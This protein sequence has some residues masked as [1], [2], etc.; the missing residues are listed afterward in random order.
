VLTLSRPEL[1]E[2]R[3]TWGAGHR[4]FSS[5]YLEPLPRDAMQRL[6]DGLVPGL[7]GAARDQI[8]ERAEGVPLYAVETA[9]MLLDRGLLVEDGP[10]YRLTGTVD[11]LEVPE[12]LHALIA[13]RLD[14]LTAAE[15]RLLQD[16]SVL[17]KTFT[18]SALAALAGLEEEEIDATL[19]SLVRKEVLNVQADPRS[20]EHGQYGFLQDLLRHVAYETLSKRDRLTRH[21]KAGAHLQSAFPDDEEVVEVLASHYLD[22]F[23]LAA[24]TD[25][26][27]E[28]GVRAREM[29][30][31]AAS[32]AASLAA[33]E[34]ARRYLERAVDLTGDR[35]EQ[36]ELLDRAGQMAWKGGSSERATAHF[37]AA[38]AAYEGAGDM[39]GSARVARRLAEVETSSGHREQAIERMERA[40]AALGDDGDEEVARL[41]AQL[42]ADYW[43]TGDPD[44]CAEM[45][46]R[47]LHI[48]E[49]LA[50]P[51]VVAHAL[52]V[53]ALVALFRGHV[54]ETLALYTHA[55][56]L[57]LENDL[58]ERAS[59]VYFNLSDLAFR[60]DR[61]RESTDYLNR[62]LAQARR[63]GE[64][65]REWE[66]LSEL[67][68][69]Q[70]ML[71]DWEASLASFA[72]IP[73]EQIQDS[74]ILISPL[75]ST[76]EIYVN[77]GRT[78]DARALVDLYR[79]LEGVADLQERACLAGA[80]AALARAEGRFTDAVAHGLEAAGAADILGFA[81]QAVKQGFVEAIEA[82]AALGELERLE[83]LLTRIESLPRG[84]RPR[85]LEA[86]AK[87]VR[88]RLHGD[89]SS[90][91]EA[92]AI[93]RELEIPFWLAVTLLEHA[94]ASN[95]EAE[96][97][98]DE[99]REIFAG[100][101]AEPWLRRLSESRTGE[102][103]PTAPR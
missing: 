99:A 28:I 92:E 85:L 50:L 97:L 45:A 51:E 35:L 60:R 63:V 3:P 69:P 29:L 54:E 33:N 65:L 11:S 74:G 39:R 78:D 87:R 12:T 96:A 30:V 49:S 32:R 26:A 21:L 76:L 6:L 8:L 57:Y 19:T 91:G 90:F 73:A 89:E 64:R 18:R 37:E 59:V 68:Y 31:R 82:A 102:A 83:D 77:R 10:G 81:S 15:R 100:L 16:A 7:P 88:A 48:A 43:F 84:Q 5:L 80:R 17:G 58:A 93:F 56:D 79:R 71:G 46:D 40:Y 94:E 23:A 20:P 101:G 24:G 72:E 38:I 36:A 47:S 70:Y 55:L 14:G 61:Y 42:A 66:I 98:L 22:A 103:V 53:K 25:E 9:R 95:G 4:N 86:H 2:R 41:T 52:S 27:T 44:R 13:A 62:A 67:T 1:A 34:E 75:T